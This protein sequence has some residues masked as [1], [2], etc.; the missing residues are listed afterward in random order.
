MYK[1]LAARNKGSLCAGYDPQI[2]PHVM[3]N[4]GSGGPEG[5]SALVLANPPI[6][7][8]KLMNGG[9]APGMPRGCGQEACRSG[10][11]CRRKLQPARSSIPHSSALNPAAARTPQVPGFESGGRPTE[12]EAAELMKRLNRRKAFWPENGRVRREKWVIG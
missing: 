2:E 10:F 12:G 5:G 11:D 3:V 9:Y 4:K 8:S 6:N 1:L 7:L